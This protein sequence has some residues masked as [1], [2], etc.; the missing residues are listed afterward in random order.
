M[1]IISIILI[2]YFAIAIGI[3]IV[4]LVKHSR[5][6]TALEEI[7]GRKRKPLWQILLPLPIYPIAVLFVG[8]VFVFDPKERHK[9][10]MRKFLETFNEEY[11]DDDDELLPY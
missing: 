3:T 6:L 7:I 1:N 10:T 9:R 11:S 8:I 2:A 5:P 4:L